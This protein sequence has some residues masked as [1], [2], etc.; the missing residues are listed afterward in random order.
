MANLP[1]S[2]PEQ[3]EKIY[4]HK[5]KAY[6]K[7]V[8]SSYNNKNFRSSVVMLYSVVVCDLIYKLYDLRD[9]HSDEKAKKILSDLNQDKE[10]NP[11]SPDWEN[12]LVEKSFKEAKILE[13]DVYTHILALKK[14]RNLSAHPVLNSLD[15]LYEPHEDLVKSHMR[16]MLDGLL[17]KSPIF[18][19]K[20][21]VPFMEE[22]ARI[23]DEFPNDDRLTSYIESK[24]LEH[25]NAELTEYIFKHLWKSVF[26]NDNELEMKNREINYK[27]LLIIFEKNQMLLEKFIEKENSFFSEFLDENLNILNKLVDFLSKYPNIYKLFKVHTKELLEN[28]IKSHDKLIVKSHFL[29]ESVYDHFEKLDN[30]FHGEAHMYFNQP[31]IHY[32]RFGKEDVKFLSELGL[33]YNVLKEF[34]DLM[35]SH[36]YHSGHFAYAD[37]AYEYC[38]E[39]YYKNFNKNQYETLFSEINHNPQCHQRNYA[40]SEHKKL[41]EDARNKFEEGFDFKTK[42][43]DVF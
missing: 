38:I 27:V 39:P 17:T 29:S 6:F 4:H 21:F 15:I 36:Y 7:E 19:K 24:F 3:I 13:N 31:Y 43:S 10:D 23:K 40:R 30:K 16:N 35:I 33:K 26:K 42:Y 5:T 37:I 32:Y 1:Y 18:T 25:F 22:V 20:I 28:R 11:V 12:E 41:L 14:D 34:Y 9:I 2:I 8:M